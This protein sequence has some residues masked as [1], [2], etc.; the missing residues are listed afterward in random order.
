MKKNYYYNINDYSDFSAGQN[1]II[2]NNITM[3]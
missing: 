3:T 2:T 1:T